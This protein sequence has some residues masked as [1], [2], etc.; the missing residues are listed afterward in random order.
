MPLNCL[1]CVNNLKVA[2]IFNSCKYYHFK[3]LTKQD[4]LF[5]HLNTDLIIL[6]DYFFGSHWQEILYRILLD[7]HDGPIIV[8]KH[9]ISETEFTLTYKNVIFVSHVSEL[10]SVLNI[11][12]EKLVIKKQV[13][14]MLS[15]ALIYESND[16]ERRIEIFEQYN[17]LLSKINA[18]T[19]KV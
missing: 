1:V 13:L 15:N 17:L 12:N 6:G 18:L 9:K 7:G 10:S 14:T 8:L 19:N 2:D 11:I 3:F 16:F 5:D 4:Y